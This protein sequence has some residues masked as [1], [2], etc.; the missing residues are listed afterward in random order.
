VGLIDRKDKKKKDLKA[1]QS[2]GHS[3]TEECLPSMCQAL[4]SIFGPAK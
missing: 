3:S 4:D 2:W 1:L